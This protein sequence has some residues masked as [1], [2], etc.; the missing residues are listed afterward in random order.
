M[1]TFHLFKRMKDGNNPAGITVSKK[2]KLPRGDFGI[3]E[4]SW[5]PLTLWFVDKDRFSADERHA[6]AVSFR[7]QGEKAGGAG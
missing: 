1:T 6:V 5:G 3:T 4:Y 2:P 7:G